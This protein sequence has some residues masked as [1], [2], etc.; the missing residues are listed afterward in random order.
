MAVERSSR[1]R[2]RPSGIRM[3]LPS[4]RIERILAGAEQYLS[5]GAEGSV[6]LLGSG[7][8]V[9]R[10]EQSDV[11]VRVRRALSVGM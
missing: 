2:V 7:G 4:G 9:C 3:I 8:A 11:C 1:G 6:C 5:A 10:R